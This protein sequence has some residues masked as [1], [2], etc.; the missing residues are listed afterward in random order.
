MVPNLQMRVLHVCSCYMAYKIRKM[1]YISKLLLFQF[2]WET[3]TFNWSWELRSYHLRGIWLWTEGPYHTD[4][5]KHLQWSMLVLVCWAW[6]MQALV[7]MGASFLFARWRW[8]GCCNYAILSL[9][10]THLT[11]YFSLTWVWILVMLSFKFQVYS[12]FPSVMV[13]SEFFAT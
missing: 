10:I 11:K 4:L 5:K 12:L 2:V 1:E 8:D 6:L 9:C 7:L 13:S 3:R